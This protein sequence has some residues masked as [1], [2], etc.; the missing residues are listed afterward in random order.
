MPGSL[1]PTWS[2]CRARSMALGRVAPGSSAQPSETSR[3][4]QIAARD[5][6]GPYCRLR[7]VMSD[8]EFDDVP[9]CR[10]SSPHLSMRGRERA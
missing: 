8:V 9:A 5:S 3:W 2:A 1:S 4:W 7:L 6:A 10:L